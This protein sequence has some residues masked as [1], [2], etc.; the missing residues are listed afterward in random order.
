MFFALAQNIFAGWEKTVDKPMDLC[1]NV[2][3]IFKDFD[4]K[5]AF[6]DVLTENRW[7]V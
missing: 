4:G 3:N 1:L 6:S 2:N 5:F 7:L